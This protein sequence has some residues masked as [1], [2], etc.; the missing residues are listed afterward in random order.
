MLCQECL[1]YTGLM[2][3]VCLSSPIV[4]IFAI[5]MILRVTGM[6]VITQ[7]NVGKEGQTFRGWVEA[8]N[9]QRTPRGSLHRREN[10]TDS[11]SLETRT[12]RC[13]K[14]GRVR[15]SLVAQRIKDLV[16]SLQQ[17]GSVLC[18]GFSPWPG[19]YICHGGVQKRKEKVN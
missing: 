6:N 8:E 12:V 10:P 18:H 15:C 5:W 17:P 3:S 13:F 16:L 11:G 9:S 2:L 7:E 4:G 14:V 19:T 1:G